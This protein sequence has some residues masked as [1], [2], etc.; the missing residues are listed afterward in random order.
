MKRMRRWRRWPRTSTTSSAWASSTW[1]RQRACRCERIRHCQDPPAHGPSTRTLCC[2]IS[3]ALPT[4]RQVVA[5]PLRD[6]Q[7]RLD[8][9]HAAGSGAQAFK[10]FLV[11]VRPFVALTVSVARVVVVVAPDGSPC[12]CRLFVCAGA[13]HLPA[14]HAAPERR[15]AVQPREG[16]ELASA[17]LPVQAQQLDP[18][19]HQPALCATRHAAVP[20]GQHLQPLAADCL[21]SRVPA[22]PGH[23]PRRCA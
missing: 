19:S 20:A 5:A 23:H 6:Q 11:Q 8:V 2:P 13:V 3:L 9:G 7:Q 22:R 12:S 21:R 18:A 14:A 15:A 17:F 16:G 10:V 1:M 4:V